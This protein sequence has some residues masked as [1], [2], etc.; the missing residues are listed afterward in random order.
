LSSR[1]EA[2]RKIPSKPIAAPAIIQIN[3]VSIVRPPIEIPYS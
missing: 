1:S 2:T 3:I